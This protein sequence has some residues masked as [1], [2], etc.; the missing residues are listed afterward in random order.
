M[1]SS[2]EFNFLFHICVSLF[3]FIHFIIHFSYL[4]LL[5][6]SFVLLNKFCPLNALTVRDNHG[7]KYITRHGRRS[8]KPRPNPVLCEC[9][10]L[11]RLFDGRMAIS[12]CRLPNTDMDTVD[13]SGMLDGADMNFT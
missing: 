1:D 10:S 12:I 7:Y 6:T 8:M 3:I 5:F 9:S 11:K 13:A 4:F 2:T